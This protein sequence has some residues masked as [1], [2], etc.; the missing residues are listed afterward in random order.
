MS[1]YN[2]AINRNTPSVSVRDNRGLNIRTLEYLRTQ[3]NETN[4]NELITRYEFNIQGF[5]VKSTDPRRYKNQ[6][7]SNFTRTFSL[8]GN[9]LREESI[10]AGR[11][12][13]LNDIEG[14]P[15]LTINATGVRQTHHY[16]GNTLPGR[17]LAV[18]ELIQKNEKTTERLIWASNTDAEKNQNLAGQCIRHYDTAG[19]VQLESLS[20][21]GAVLSQSRQLIAEN[22][23]ADWHGDDENSWRTKLN[24]NIFTTQNK[25]DAIGALLT[26]IDAKGNI[27]RLAYDVAGQLKGS[28]L[29]LKG[30]SEKVIVQSI[31][32]SAAGQKLREEHGNGVI[33]EYTYEPETQRLINIKTRR[34]KDST[35]P[36]QDL[37]YEYDP[38]GNVINIRNDAEATRFWRNQK[39]VPENA[40][41]YDSLYQLII[42]TGREMAN[43][44]QQGSQLPPL[45]TP[46]PTDDNTYTNYTRTYTYDDSGNLTQIRHSAPASNNNYTTDIT[47]SNRNNRGVLSTL[48]NDPNLVDTFF[49]AGG[50]QTSLLSGQSLNWTPR[51]ELQQVNQSGNS[52]REWY[53]YDSDGMRLLKINE[54]QT[55]NATQQQRVTYLPGLELHTTQSGANIT[56]DLQVIAVGQAGRAQVRVLHWEKGQPTGIDND[57]VRY[58]Y[59]NLTHSSE[60]ELD[61]HGEII[62]WEE[63]YPYGGTAIWAARNQVEAGYKTIRYSGKERDA[64]GLYYYG[65]RYY[66]PWAGRWL[67]ADPA[68]TVDGLNLYRMVRNN[69][70]TGIDED[71]RIFKTVATGALGVGGIAY[72]L[73]KH[74]NQQAERPQMPSPASESYGDQQVSKITQK[75]SALKA[76]YDPMKQ[77][78]H[79]IAGRKE[80]AEHLAQGQVP[81]AQA[82]KEGASLVAAAGE[83]AAAGN[84]GELN[85]TELTKAAGTDAINNFS[86]TFDGIKKV[87]KA[88][89]ATA[90]VTPE[91]LE[92][93]QKATDDLKEVATDTLITGA[94]LGATVGAT[95]DTAAAVVPHPVAKVAFKG[96]SFAWKVTGVVHT[97]EELSNLAEKHKDLVSNELG[98]ELKREV[99][100]ANQI[101]RGTILSK[102]REHGLIK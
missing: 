71:G 38:V 67:S 25:T 59:D 48:T 88:G 15:V 95:L 24:D 39:I 83:F 18:T 57:Q 12:V 86:L 8:A 85:K 51:G 98:Q 91:K 77:I 42:A 79:N 80:A 56:E 64:T 31:T 13:T 74:K 41:T 4:S 33:T 6:S 60:L 96:L 9:T 16:E 32:W 43:I 92:E 99:T 89:A 22:Q 23:E 97:A 78:A 20:L 29:T 76:N 37:R 35:K 28:W 102:V 27:Q 14:R 94:S 49:D 50:H 5:Q 101:R 40:Y 63:Y 19:L 61:M 11:T 68:G 70:M 65:Y 93:L 7:G 10:D 53:R 3:A 54:Q 34:T 75:A 62:S 72:E 90:T 46:L 100:E 84:I 81:G 30:Q 55:P 66:Q 26:Q 58:S 21:T 52:A 47:I 45:V 1:H 82:I 87:F 69:P 44:S 2:S 36:L 73:Y 17:L